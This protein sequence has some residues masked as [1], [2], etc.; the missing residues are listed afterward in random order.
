MRRTELRRLLKEGIPI[1]EIARRFDVAPAT[2]YNW[3]T[4]PVS[5]GG[6][7]RG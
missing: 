4:K 7:L 6:E 3:K 5:R 1:L 2:I